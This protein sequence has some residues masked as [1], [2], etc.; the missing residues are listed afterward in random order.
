MVT[1]R[2]NP[3]IYIMK[4]RIDM[5]RVS[6]IQWAVRAL[7]LLLMVAVSGVGATA[8]R[9][10][11]VAC[12]GNSI[13]YGYLLPDPSTQSYPAQLGRMLGAGY[14]VRNFGHSGA[15]LMKRGHN[16]YDKLPECRDAMAFA[17]DIAVI[18]LGINDTDPRDW[19]DYGS[20]FERDYESLIAGFRRANPDV[21]V[22]IARLTPIK[23]EHFRYRSGTEV[24]R[25]KIQR[26]IENVARAT[27]VEL[28]DF[29][30]PLLDRQDLM[31]D[32]L[33]PNEE[34]AG[35]LAR[36]VAGAITGDYGGL[37]LW[38]T[39]SD[40]AVV[41]RDVPLRVGGRANARKPVTVTVGGNSYH[42]R[43]DVEGRWEL[44]TAPLAA[45]GPY[46]ITATDGDTTIIVGDVLAGE[47]WIASGQSNMAF[48]LSDSE[49]GREAV[50]TSGDTLLRFFDMEPIA[51]TVDAMW[52]DSTLAA[53]DRLGYF[54][55]ARWKSVNADNAGGLSAVA[56]YFARALR[57]SLNVPVGVIHNSVGGAPI[58]SWTDAA[59][60]MHSLPEAL[61]DWRGNDYLQKWVQQRAVKNSGDRHR[62][63]YEPGYLFGAGV[64]PL[65]PVN[66]A[67]TIWYQG[68]SNAHNTD[69]YEQLFPVMAASW[70]KHFRMP[71]MPLLT[72]Q[73][74]SIDRPSWPEFRDA[75]RRLAATMEGVEIAVSSDLGD[76]LNVHPTR[77]REVGERLARQAL[78]H[79]YGRDITASGPSVRRAVAEGGSVRLELDD[80]DGLTT[81]DGKAPA[82]FEIA[83]IDGFY[84]RAT[85]RIDNDE[86]IL[87]AMDIKRPRYVRYAWQPFT[88][89]N[90]VNGEQ[91]PMSTFKMEV[92]N[93][94]DYDAEAGIENGVSGSFAG[95]AGKNLVMIA[96]GCNFPC[97]QPLSGDA[98]K[99]FYK[100]IYL[101]DTATGVWH[102]AGSL[103]EA[104]AYGAWAQTPDGIVIAGGSNADG[105]QRDA[106]K[107]T[108]D[109][110]TPQ[111]ESLPELP[112]AIDNGYGAAIGRIV[113][114]AG[115]NH[116]GV[117]SNDMY[118]LDLDNLSGG[119]RKLRPMPG[120]PRVQPV[121]ASGKDSDGKDRLWLW[122]GFAGRY[123]GHEPTLELGG[124]CYD[125]QKNKWTAV[126]PLVD[127][128]GEAVST[129]GG[130]AATLSDG[131][132]AIVGGVN[133]TVFIEALR[134]QA[135]DY[136]MHPVSWYGF[137][138]SV[139]LYDPAT[140]KSEALAPN[141]DAARAGASMV[142]LEDDKIF[143]CGGEL[144][145]R[146]RTS[147]TL[148]I[149][150]K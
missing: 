131:R 32:A 138:G 25:D 30:A 147:E 73:L 21:R 130:S 97:L 79:V 120:N 112:A 142:A 51:Q 105:P 104:I 109:G 115:G 86:I 124:L 92:D 91:L 96:G 60:L 29:E 113:Y 68:E 108:F 11:K 135:P 61:V 19:P 43:A 125:P 31:V 145:P 122:G 56:Y 1:C 82:I 76:S 13:T 16:P 106:Y 22:L 3:I 148:I 81:S 93:A 132:I 9:P 77:K 26:S 34:G 117:P 48:Y 149:D 28:I 141:P 55:P 23:T 41:Q 5:L 114:V 42:A 103:P 65:G 100:G 54:K 144:K 59:A 52:R 7:S 70:R 45:G 27:G 46:T 119:W 57:D 47:V 118:A 99:K 49:G 143:L 50:A 90:V 123:E 127:A 128:S 129:G 44:T 20:E 146:I 10:T 18:H 71:E 64:R 36:T 75:Q 38:S 121:M 94:S 4:K 134:N 2:R 37:S 102:R 14:E 136:L 111:V 17:P 84:S 140:G 8:K 53:V 88:R 89:S 12:V 67:G 24:W 58:E 6:A 66:I 83:E 74:S 69:L 72:V 78:Y 133:K 139:I 39:L 150:C 63:P 101:M 35:V 62:H 85:A 80:S 15:T 107:I 33:H 116:D 110:T 40:G 98:Q 95:R 126:A 137:N 87:T